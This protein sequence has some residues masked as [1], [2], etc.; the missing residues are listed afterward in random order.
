MDSDGSMMPTG[1]LSKSTAPKSFLMLSRGLPAT[2]PSFATSAR[3]SLV[4]GETWPLESKVCSFLSF[5]NHLTGP[6][7]ETEI[8]RGQ[9]SRDMEDLRHLRVANHLEKKN[10]SPCHSSGGQS[11]R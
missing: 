2:M 8:L 3:C 5:A 4:L 7:L 9:G 10:L 11:R 1:G 6:R